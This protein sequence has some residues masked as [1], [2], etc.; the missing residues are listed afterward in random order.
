MFNLQLTLCECNL[1]NIYYMYAS[2]FYTELVNEVG[3]ISETKKR[4]D[5]GKVST[6]LW[7]HKWITIKVNTLFWNNNLQFYC[8][9]PTSAYFFFSV[10]ACT[11][12]ISLSAADRLL[13]NMWVQ[14]A[15]R[16]AN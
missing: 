9:D 4:L 14:D 3:I 7:A 8:G 2:R 6:P 10:T 15:S 16:S 11:P 12:L 1:W 5:V 13:I